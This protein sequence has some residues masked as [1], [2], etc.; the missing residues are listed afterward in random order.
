MP[1][2]PDLIEAT[3]AKI[4]QRGVFTFSG[5]STDS[6]TINKDELFIALSGPNFD[7]HDFLAA[8]LTAGAGAI[9][10][11]PL[12]AGFSLDKSKSIL[13]VDDTLAALQKIARYIRMKRPDMPVA[14]VTGSNGKTTTKE[15]AALVLGRR[16]KVL[17]SS[18]N[19]NNQIGLP[20]NLCRLDDRH[21]AAVLEMGASR[22]GDI[23]ELCAIA[24]PTHG[25]ITNVSESHLE[26]F[27]TF[28]ALMETKLALASA[29]GAFVY[30]ADDPRLSNA[31]QSEFGGGKNKKVKSK[32]GFGMNEG[33]ELRAED[34][35][36]EGGASTFRLSGRGQ[37]AVL[38]FSSAGLFNV[39]NALAAAACGLLFDISLSEAASALTEFSGVPMRYGIT[40]AAGALILGDVYNANPASMDA[41]LLELQRLRG[42]RAVAVLGDMLE[43]GD[44]SEEAHR[45]LGRRLAS[46]P[47]DIF[48]AVGPMMN[49]AREEF[50]ISKGGPAPKNK[51]KNKNA[52]SC[53]DSAQAGSLLMENLRAGDTVLIKGSR[54]VQMERVLEYVS[55][56]DGTSVPGKR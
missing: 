39:Y 8:A 25:I 51:N 4:L 14:G 21:G 50:L 15:L 37:S 29:A 22:P 31:V 10:S 28:K 5:L 12:K 26:G 52:F 11:R 35:R 20:L 6:R 3:G 48:I 30:N 36:M 9:I 43:L 55:G 2:L 32:I 24:R 19:F 23:A 16:F 1:G 56:A 41:A 18:G 7:G 49:L 46:L 33:A 54:G 44:Y 27:T 17:K 45:G 42:K 13:L 34:I 40:Q 53:A 47:V 38:R